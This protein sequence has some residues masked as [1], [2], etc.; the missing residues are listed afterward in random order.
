[1]TGTGTQA[2]PY[3]P[4]TL[5]E[6]ITAVGT[7]GAYVAL[8]QDI[9]A[10]DD[11]EYSGELTTP[12]T[13]AAASVQGGGFTLLGLT[14]RTSASAIRFAKGITIEAMMLEIA[15]KRDARFDML[16]AYGSGNKPLF[17]SC[18][19]RIKLDEGAYGGSFM[20]ELSFQDCA[21][22]ISTTAET[23]ANADFFWTCDFLRTTIHFTSEMLR[24]SG[25]SS[26]FGQSCTFVRSAAIFEQLTA[27]G[28][29]ILIVGSGAAFNGIRY[30]YSAVLALSGSIAINHSGTSC[31]I[32]IDPSASIS[33][34]PS[35]WTRAT[36]AQM[37]DKDWLTSVGFLP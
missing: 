33:S 11:P 34:I 9:N 12:I 13:L 27:S 28:G 24:A 7:A 20:D 30:S 21:M 35:G 31:I 5:T 29:N 6:F 14:L 4:T 10:A 22:S 3:I 2:D 32:A 16:V 26:I 19:F 1:M 25:A 18:L 17:S 36:L 15:F 23:A 37:Q 8:T